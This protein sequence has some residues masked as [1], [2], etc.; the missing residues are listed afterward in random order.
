[1]KNRLQAR[2]RLHNIGICNTDQCLLCEDGIEDTEH[3]FFTCKFSS[4][5]LKEVKSWMGVKNT[6]NNLAHILAWT[7]RR[8]KGGKF[9]KR[10]FIASIIAAVMQFGKKEIMPYGIQKYTL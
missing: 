3:L 8:F 2:A 6:S 4:Q 10:I 5:V 1:M 7:R 9:R